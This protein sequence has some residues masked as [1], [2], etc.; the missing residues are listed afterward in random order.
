MLLG[1]NLIFRFD[2]KNS[3]RVG[4]IFEPTNPARFILNRNRQKKIKIE[5]LSP[6]K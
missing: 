3:L 6:A 5:N 4:V 2:A 1:I